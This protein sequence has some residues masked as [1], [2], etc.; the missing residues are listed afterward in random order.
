LPDAPA[1]ASD[2]VTVRAQLNG[3]AAKAERLFRDD[4]T[5]G[6]VPGIRRIQQQMHVGQP[7]ARLVQQHL[8]TLAAS[9]GDSEAARKPAGQLVPVSPDST[10]LK[11]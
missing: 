3:H 8:K 6:K 10:A 9:D 11:G 7:K 5:A 4:L 1:D 2:P